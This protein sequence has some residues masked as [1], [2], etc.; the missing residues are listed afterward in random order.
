MPTLEVECRIESR[1]QELLELTKRLTEPLESEEV[2]RVVVDQAQAA[3]D[4]R[5]VC[6]WLVDDE[7]THAT[8]V[9]AVGINEAGREKYGRIPVEPWLPMGDAM[10]RR[11]PLFF[12]CRAQLRAQYAAAEEAVQAHHGS[13]DL[14]YVCLPLTAQGRAIGGLS[15]VFAGHRTFTSD[16]RLF[17]ALIAHH[18]TQALE[19]ANLFDRERQARK[20]AESLQRFTSVISSTA[21]AQGVAELAARTVVET[22]GFAAAA[23]WTTDDRGD[24]HLLRHHGMEPE[25]QE[26]FRLIPG[27][28]TLPA[29]RVARE[30]LPVWCESEQD[31]RAEHESIVTAVTRQDTMHAFG[32]LPLVR[33][34]RVLG[35]LAFNTPG[36]Q[37]I[38][39]EARAFMVTVA[40]HCAD[41]L[42]RA[43]LHDDARSTKQLFQSVLE[44]LP[45]GV[46]VSR[47]PD[48]TLV[49]SNDALG[50]IWRAKVFPAR[51]EERCKMLRVMYPD[52][53]PIPFSESPVQRALRGEVV[54]N[55][56]GRIERQDGTVGWI[57]AS[58]APVFRDDGT[59]EVAVATVVDV[60]AEKEARAVAI[61][62]T[63]AKDEFL[64]MLG[65]ELRN[66]LAPIVTALDIMNLRGGE[67]FRAERTLVS[68]QVRHLVRL[69]D[70]LLD[71]SRI[72]R[73]KIQL[74]AEH[75]EVATVIAGAI[76]IATPL[77]EQRSHKL[78]VEVPP[79]GLPLLVDPG[80]LSQAVANLLTNAAKYTEPG[81]TITITAA[82]DEREVC[83]RV[84]D[85]GIGIDAALLPKMFDLFMQAHTSIDRSQGGLGL[86]LTIA[87]RLVELQGGSISGHSSG[88]GHGSEFVIRLPLHSGA[89]ARPQEGEPSRAADPVSASRW[90]VLIVDDNTEIADILALSLGLLGCVT[91]VANDAPS[92][93]AAAETFAADLAI[94]DIGLPV[95]NGYELAR[96][97]RATKSTASM[98]LVALTGYGQEMDRQ[99]SMEAGF[100]EHIVKPVD[101]ATIRGILSRLST[102]EP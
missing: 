26:M 62:A 91:R 21:T 90:R 77:I 52:G 6:L 92:A 43:R 8:L 82:R 13:R 38:P 53:R 81:G 59:V 89:E 9:R 94:L 93:I 60:T 75:I 5:T 66:P 88:L 56:E 68:R 63:R 61:E 17:F 2:V 100:D 85:T 47:A 4:A 31:I 80:R 41:A 73:G 22:L 23:I 97:F 95:M 46:I 27:D 18:A 65:H 87:R 54:N 69:V 58:A 12:E 1:L 45:V 76:E 16:E 57:Q 40:E 28:S 32:V 30:R 19:R 25:D 35:V 70:D 44:R 42:A 51:G 33:S 14:S 96:Q 55:L 11:E 101:L 37:R 84:K 15:F 50:R 64:A 29:A 36:P 34:D 79:G 49:L 3:V 67:A 74:S 71:I 24:L 83:I 99:R 78:N 72:T 10:M 20:R 7:P 48:S 98:R 39:P 86:G 102:R